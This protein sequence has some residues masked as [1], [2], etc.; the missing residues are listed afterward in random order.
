MDP[1]FGGAKKWGSFFCVA[2]GSVL[3]L[4]ENR[5][6]LSPWERN[7]IKQVNTGLGHVDL[8]LLHLS[9]RYLKYIE[10]T[11]ATEGGFFRNLASSALVSIQN[12]KNDSSNQLKKHTP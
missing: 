8:G 6:S 10:L 3:D 4:F 9:S 11:V 5:T 7:K 1:V 12:L 2:V